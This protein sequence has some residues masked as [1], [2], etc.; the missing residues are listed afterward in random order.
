M[1]AQQ[2]AAETLYKGAA[3]PEGG[4]TAGGGAPGGGGP[5]DEVIDAEIVDEKK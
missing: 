2:K 4:P 1:Q 5:T 3:G